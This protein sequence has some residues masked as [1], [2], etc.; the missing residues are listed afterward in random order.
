MALK[1]ADMIPCLAVISLRLY[2][3]RLLDAVLREDAGSC[4]RKNVIKCCAKYGQE[5]QEDRTLELETKVHTKV[6]IHRKG[7]Y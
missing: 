1:I 2:D 5:E 7:P 6:R 3:Y 4:S